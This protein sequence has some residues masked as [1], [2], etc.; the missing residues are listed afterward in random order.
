[1]TIV[2]HLI[3]IGVGT[4]TLSKQK[5][6]YL[7]LFATFVSWGSL[8]VVSKFVLGKI[9]VITV[10][11]LRY[12]IAS[13]FLLLIMKQRK[14]LKKIA[15]SDYK[16]VFLIGFFGY[17]IAIGA[18]LL[19]TKLTS[20]SLASLVNSMNPIVIMLFATLI[21]HEKLTLKMLVCGILAIFGVYLIVGDV[22]S[23]GEMW[24]IG[25]SLFSVILWSFVTVVVRKVT[26]K[27]DAI[28]ITTYAVLVAA[29][30]TLPFS[31]VECMVT[32]NIQFDY[33]ALLAMLYIG[34]V[35]TGVSHLL[36]NKSLSLIEAGTCSMFYPIQPLV[37]V[38]LGWLFLG[39]RLSM[40]FLIGSG[41]I[42]AGVV[43]SLVKTGSKSPG[44]H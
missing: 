18:Q 31:I 2:F 9:P 1:M 22:G 20:A 19:G 42:I 35:C 40:N 21:L 12:A 41:I 38:L 16:Y 30:C 43:L 25:V 10:S 39:E 33:S 44:L 36:W 26:Q 6:A 5:T 8:Y 11:F 3:N 24:G 23:K 14:P 28:Q 7:Y 13:A 29:V 15:R 37:A 32:S 17:F 27:Y 4:M 34:F